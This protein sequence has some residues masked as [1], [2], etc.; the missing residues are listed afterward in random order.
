MSDE[1]KN[2][3]EKKETERFISDIRN[4]IEEFPE[5]IDGVAP[6]LKKSAEISFSDAF[7]EARKGGQKTFVWKCET[8]STYLKV[9]AYN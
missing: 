4:L 8:Y 6:S 2:T 7:L 1:E 3:A 5:I 9:G